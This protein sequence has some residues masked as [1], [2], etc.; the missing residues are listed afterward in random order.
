M[1]ITIVG[2]GLIGGSFAMA[3]RERDP[4]NLWAVEVDEHTIITAQKRGII[5]KGYREGAV[6]LRHSDIVII[7]LYPDAAASFIKDN[8]EY[9]KK[10]AVI[11]DTVG[12][13]SGLIKRINPILRSDLDFV[14]GHPLAGRE[15]KGLEFA[16]ADAF[17]GAT[18]I[19]TPTE[20]N[21]ERALD[22]VENVVREA[23]FKTVL[24]ISPERHDETIALTSQLPHV[25]AAALINSG[26]GCEPGLLAAGSYKDSTRVARINSKLWV[27]LLLGNRENVLA[28]I[29]SFEGCLAEI[30]KA[31][32]GNE[33]QAL[34]AI[35]EEVRIK[36]EGIMQ[37]PEKSL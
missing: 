23:G 12:I 6:P 26:G 20:R 17:A 8:M 30:K 25:I 36:R 15:Y 10:G 27:E 32:A 7:C 19:I 35:L 3:L 37:M 5:D 18:Y 29:E 9:F 24:R 22:L 16:S 14:A 1:S 33:A 13:K 11:T 2:L 4:K 31:I 21:D 28:R 34:G